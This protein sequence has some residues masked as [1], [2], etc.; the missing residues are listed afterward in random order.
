M[1]IPHTQGKRILQFLKYARKRKRSSEDYFEFQRFQ[2]QLI[3]DVLQRYT[4]FNKPLTILDIGSG[5]GGYVYEL[6]QLKNIEIVSLDKNPLPTAIERYKKL[7]KGKQKKISKALRK[8]AK[9]VYQSK[10]I[11]VVEGDI[12]QAPLKDQAFDIIIASGVIEHVANQQGM[13]EECRRLLKKEGIFYLSF[14]PYYAPT[15]GHSISPL[16]YLP[17]KIPFLLYKRMHVKDHE[18]FVYYGLYKTTLRSVKTL[19]KGKF[20][21][22]DINPR[23][24]TFLKPL[25][26]VP[27]L[28]E[29]ISHHV[30]LILKK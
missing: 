7:N 27:L 13:L 19:I 4:E 11:T 30:E 14:P 29:A 12:T 26:K 15:G 1:D 22:I 28:N 9:V 5:I 8:E 21:I 18:S 17:G 20:Q 16:H 24:F 23:L 10:N 6:A 25:L 3:I 2:G